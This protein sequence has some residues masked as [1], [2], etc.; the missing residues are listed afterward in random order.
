MGVASFPVRVTVAIRFVL[1]SPSLQTVVDQ[2]MSLNYLAFPSHSLGL[3]D[4]LYGRPID[5]A[6]STF[7][8]T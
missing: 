2:V 4:K 3:D 7:H 6:T 8:V 1:D 5:L